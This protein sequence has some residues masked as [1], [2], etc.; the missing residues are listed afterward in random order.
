M[1][2]I[3]VRT[4]VLIAACGWAYP[5]CSAPL[6]TFGGVYSIRA[7]AF[8][9]AFLGVPNSDHVF[10]QPAIVFDKSGVRPSR[11]R[12]AF[13]GNAGA[14]G[15]VGYAAGPGFLSVYANTLANAVNPADFSQSI[16]GATTFAEA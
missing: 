14:V 9:G 8:D 11:D 13:V 2:M 7:D 3:P 10:E 6:Q 5:A 16:G 1:R 4:A 12:T 15:V